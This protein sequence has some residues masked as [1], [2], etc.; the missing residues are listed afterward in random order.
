MTIDQTLNELEA[1]LAYDEGST[2][3]GVSDPIRRAELAARLD[4]FSEEELRVGLSVWLRD[5]YLSDEGLGQGYGWED[6]YAF[7][8]WIIMGDYRPAGR[9]VNGRDG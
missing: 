4:A 1:H 8:R 9:I 2:D 6:A 3:S 7:C 5:G